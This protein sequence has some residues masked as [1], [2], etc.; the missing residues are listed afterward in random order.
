MTSPT[1]N[2]LLGCVLCL[3]LAGY[4][5]VA[6]AAF[7]DGNK[8]HEDCKRARYFVLGYV[9][10]AY[11]AA[12]LGQN[13]TFNIF[14]AE[15]SSH[16]EV[17]QKVSNAYSDSVKSLGAYCTPN[18]VILN[19][20]VDIFCQYLAAHPGERQKSGNQLLAT[21]LSEAWPCKVAMPK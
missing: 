14:W 5:C 6:H 15:L 20:V 10:G 19:Q 16:K 3:I 1:R 18:G 2:T 17:D 21:A 11:D 8:L 4:S 9:A 13:A 7:Y 12:E